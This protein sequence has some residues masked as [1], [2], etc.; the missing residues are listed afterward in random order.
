MDHEDASID[1]VV[2]S[3]TRFRTLLREEL[4]RLIPRL[5]LNSEQGDGFGWISNRDLMSKLRLSKATLARWRS[6]L[7]LPHTKVGG[8]VFYRISDVDAFLL[9]HRKE[10]DH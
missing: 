10:P 2:L 6:T 7:E 5:E 8:S 3:A 9:A 4:D 1:L